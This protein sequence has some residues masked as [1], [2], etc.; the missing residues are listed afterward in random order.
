MVIQKI[1]TLYQNNDVIIINKPAG[2][3]VTKDR[4]GRPS[5]LDLIGGQLSGSLSSQL[6]LVHRLDKETSGVMIVAKSLDSQRYFSSLFEK[7]LVRKTYLAL[8]TGRPSADSGRIE[9]PIAGKKENTN[10]MCIDRKRGKAAITDWR[11]IADFGSVLLLAVNPLTG[12]THQIR[13]HLSSIGMDIVEDPLYGS[14][15]SLFLSAFKAAYKLGKNQIEQ[16]LIDRLALHSYQLEFLEMP[17]DMPSLFI[18]PLDKKF[19]AAVKIL[20]KYNSRGHDAFFEP[21]MF[22]KILGASRI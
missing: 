18:A 22:E 8:V 16:P 10:I 6:R 19:A 21:D 13:V 9:S 3:S 1:E 5:L 14:K 15:P 4:T 2:L 20:T 12:R 11:V 7:R 17:A